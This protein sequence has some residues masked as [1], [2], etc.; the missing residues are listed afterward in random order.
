[1][2]AV[3]VNGETTVISSGTISYYKF[4]DWKDLQVQLVKL[5]KVVKEY[6]EQP[7]ISFR[8][9]LIQ[10]N[11]NSLF[12]QHE[13]TNSEYDDFL[14]LH[15]SSKNMRFSSLTGIT[16]DKFTINP[17]FQED[18]RAKQCLEEFLAPKFFENT[19]RDI[20]EEID[21]FAASMEQE[22]TA[23]FT[24]KEK[25]T[26]EVNAECEIPKNLDFLPILK[27]GKE[28]MEKWLKI[29]TAFLTQKFEKDPNILAC[30][31][32]CATFRKE[33]RDTINKL[34]KN[35]QLSLQQ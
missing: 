24:E 35:S 12:D 7:T 28:F 10:K 33:G 19:K 6:S 18:T 27:E 1:M 34:A 14:D 3:T 8:S 5:S 32:E 13:F 31:L 17:L 30:K 2:Y 26:K 4:E 16:K 21:N 25:E 20:K 15:F 23:F 9:M 29:K 22:F 11:E